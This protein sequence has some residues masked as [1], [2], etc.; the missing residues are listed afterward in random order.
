VQNE[1][2]LILLNKIKLELNFNKANQALTYK[3]FVNILK[4]NNIRNEL[5]RLIEPTSGNEKKSLS[6]RSKSNI[7]LNIS[8]KGFV[9]F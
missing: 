3:E 6:A 2:N 4:S 9:F 8:E 7:W 5:L 1:S